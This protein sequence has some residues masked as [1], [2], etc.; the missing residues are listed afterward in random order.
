MICKEDISN[1][2]EEL[3]E[4]I[5]RKIIIKG[6]KGRKRYFEEE[7]IIEKTYSNIFTVKSE[8]KDANASYR[9][10]EILTKD[11]QISIFDGKD[12]SPLVP[13]ILKQ[14]F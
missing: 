4:N 5:G 2:K 11:L 6:A 7:V 13:V 3:K 14:K 10:T 9:Y 8:K 12:Y 1:L